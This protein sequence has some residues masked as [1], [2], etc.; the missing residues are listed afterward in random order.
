MRRD[1]PLARRLDPK[2][3]P[4]LADATIAPE[5]IRMIRASH[6][7]EKPGR[8]LCSDPALSEEAKA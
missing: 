6:D 5:A 7:D 8:A 2:E 4:A 3:V 1:D